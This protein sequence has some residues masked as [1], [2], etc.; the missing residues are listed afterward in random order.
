[1]YKINVLRS[2]RKALELGSFSVDCPAVFQHP[3]NAI[4]LCRDYQKI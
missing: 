3:T 4:F 1:M 2:T